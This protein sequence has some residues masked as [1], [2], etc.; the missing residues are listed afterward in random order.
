MCQRPAA[1]G[2]THPGCIHPFGI[3]GLIAIWRYKGKI[4]Q[5]ISQLKFKFVKQITGRLAEFVAIEIRQDERLQALRQ[6]VQQSIW[7]GVPLHSS[8]ERWRGFNQSEAIAHQLSAALGG[9][10]LPSVLERI[11]PTSPQVGLQ[12]EEREENIR[13]AFKTSIP[14]K[15]Q[16]II[17]VD[18]VWTTGATMQEA[19][20]VLKRSGAKSVWGFALAR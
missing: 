17:L 9:N 20:R 14:T 4:K 11:R 7:L 12:R 2:M 1:Y 18:D 8:R 10:Y 13:G 3:D 15:D 5:V 19:T 16:K 6:E